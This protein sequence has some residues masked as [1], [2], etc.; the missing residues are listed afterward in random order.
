MHPNNVQYL[1][2]IAMRFSQLDRP[3]AE[4]EFL[5]Y[6]AACRALAAHA[7][8]CEAVCHAE[9]SKLSQQCAPGLEEKAI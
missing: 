1:F 3:F 6:E 8:L 2:G 7:L 9:S 5:L 4:H